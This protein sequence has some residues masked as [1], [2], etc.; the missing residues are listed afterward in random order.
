MLHQ[1][2]LNVNYFSLFAQDPAPTEG[3]PGYITPIAVSYMII[4]QY[5]LLFICKV[6]KCIIWISVQS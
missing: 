4:I 6:M 5:I 3:T 1:D 2:H